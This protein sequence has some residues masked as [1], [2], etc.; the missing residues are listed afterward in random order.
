MPCTTANP[1]PLDGATGLSVHT[2][3]TWTGGDPDGDTVTYDVH[4]EAGDATPGTLICHDAVNTTCDPGTL[5]Y[6][7]HYYWRV[8]ATDEHAASTT[9]PVWDMTTQAASSLSGII[10]FMRCITDDCDIQPR[11]KPAGI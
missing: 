4:L 3:L 6:N 2:N 10:L 1:R 8:V 5:G 11:W 7:T 9:G